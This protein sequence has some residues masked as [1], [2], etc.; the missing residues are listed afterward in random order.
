M[1]RGCITI[2]CEILYLNLFVAYNLALISGLQ[3][4]LNICGDYHY[5]A[6]HKI[7]FNCNKT[8]VFCCPKKYKQPAPSNVFLTCV[9]V[10]LSEQVKSC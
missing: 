2:S 10:Q 8:I 1:S 5:A 9:C 7:A 3:C 4:L 6:E